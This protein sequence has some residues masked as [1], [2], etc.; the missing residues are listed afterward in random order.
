MGFDRR[1]KSR[2]WP[3]AYRADG[4][5]AASDRDPCSGERFNGLPWRVEP[6][7]GLDSDSDLDLDPALEAG[8]K[9]TNKQPN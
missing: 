1:I 6:A 4:L 8:S 7:L 2:D 3:E 5:P 9:Q